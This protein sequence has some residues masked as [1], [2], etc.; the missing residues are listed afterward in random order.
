MKS[1]LIDPQV[2]EFGKRF[3]VGIDWFIRQSVMQRH[4]CVHVPIDGHF[5]TQHAGQH[6]AHTSQLYSQNLRAMS[7]LIRTTWPAQFTGKLP[8]HQV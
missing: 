5:W 6:T 2:I 1:S 3:G 4:G 8:I 7:D